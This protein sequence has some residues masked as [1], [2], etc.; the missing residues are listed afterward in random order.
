MAKSLKEH[1]HFGIDATIIADSTTLGNRI[2]S[3]VV[4]FPRIV[5]AE[6][7]T[8][9]MFSRNSASSRAIPT[10]KMF[11]R[12]KENPFIPI[13]F[14][15]AHKGMQ[16]SEYFEG[17]DLEIAKTSWLHARDNAL[18][19]AK[20]LDHLGVTKQLVNRV[21]EPFLWHTVIVTSTEWE[22]YFNL[23]DHEAA[24]IHIAALAKKMREEMEASTPKKL[25]EG[26]WHIPFGDNMDDKEIVSYLKSQRSAEEEVATYEV[27]EAK[28]KIAVA[29]CAR[30]SY[31]NPDGN[32][33]IE[34]DLKLYDRL[35]GMG[36][37]SPFE[38]VA[39]AMSYTEYNTHIKGIAGDFESH[40]TITEV[41]F[42][43]DTEEEKYWDYNGWSRNFRGFIQL[44]AETD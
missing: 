26:E 30:V 1:N 4:T 19:R 31:T 17:Q 16:G 18:E 14:Q 38:H 40:A 44:R 8:H 34:K 33:D 42:V 13:A 20:H 11:Q 29:R 37:W 35:A 10:K 12:V 25:K 23:R 6:F 2:V 41:M 22:N 39:R 3:Y 36:H 7:N 21:L 43:D 32:E 27:D 15:K 9:R 28:Q 24:E 5:L